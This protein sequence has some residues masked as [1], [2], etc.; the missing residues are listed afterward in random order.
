MFFS[1]GLFNYW[2]IENGE[3]KDL[4]DSNHITGLSNSNFVQ[5][6]FNINESSL[7]LNNGFIEVPHEIHFDSEFTI[8][9]WVNLKAYLKYQTL[10]DFGN[11]RAIDNII[12]NLSGDLNNNLTAS[13]FIDTDISNSLSSP[14]LELN[15]WNH[16][17]FKVENKYA[18]IYINGTITVGKHIDILGYLNVTRKKNYFGKSNWD[19]HEYDKGQFILDDIKIFK[20]GLLNSEIKSEFEKGYY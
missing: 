2:P 4:V 15:T 19:D 7:N 11:G 20:R 13:I 6:R 12:L 17:V 1:F 3:I 14:S 18:S 8:L 9:T 10:F 5:D 16:I